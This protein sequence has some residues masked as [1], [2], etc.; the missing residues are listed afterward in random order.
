MTASEK[1]LYVALRSIFPLLLQGQAYCT[2]RNSTPHSSLFARLAS[3][4]FC[5][6]IPILQPHH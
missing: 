6:A 3:G 2:V 1:A 5:E 4:A